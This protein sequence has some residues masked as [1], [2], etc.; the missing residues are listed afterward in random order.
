MIY[1]IR[2][3]L[4]K[5]SKSI[6]L[7]AYGRSRMPFTSVSYVPF[8]D[9]RRMTYR[10]GLTKEEE[11]K[12]SALL[13]EDLSSQSKYW[14]NFRVQ[15]SADTPVYKFD[16][17]APLDYLKFKMLVANGLVCPDIDEAG[18]PEY[19]GAQYIA[20]TEDAVS[21]KDTDRNI[22]IDTAVSELLKIKDNKDKMLLYGRYLEGFKYSPS[23]NVSSLYNL[24]REYINASKDNAERFLQ[25]IKMDVE[26]IQVKIV[27][28]NAVKAGYIKKS[29]VGKGKHVYQYGSATL[30]STLK[31]V[32]ANLEKP[33][34]SPDLMSIREKIGQ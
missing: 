33:E 6:G 9:E 17:D 34:F 26:D 11:V 2:Q 5:N 29:A 25:T 16:M 7:D 1:N 12:Y 3:K 14:N 22:R 24:L 20:Y 15:F 4:D 19:A 32:Y 23:M 28:D 31:E 13:K 18:A 10:T 27:V 30:G 8:Y 21:K